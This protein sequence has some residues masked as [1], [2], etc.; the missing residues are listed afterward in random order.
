MRR[1]GQ[2]YMTKLIVAFLSFAEEPEKKGRESSRPKMES[3]MSLNQLQAFMCSKLNFKS[4]YRPT[5]KKIYEK[6]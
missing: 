1:D 2:T 4:L 6:L 3:I 5:N